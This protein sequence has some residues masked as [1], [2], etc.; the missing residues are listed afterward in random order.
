M[1]PNRAWSAALYGGA[2]RPLPRIA[3]CGLKTRENTKGHLLTR[4][5]LNP[6]S[7]IRGNGR[8]APLENAALQALFGERAAHGGRG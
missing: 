4:D 6:Q 7:A 3:D 5:V 8:V 2:T 1:N